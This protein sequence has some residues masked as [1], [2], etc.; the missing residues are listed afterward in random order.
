M[1]VMPALDFEA[2]ARVGGTLIFLMSVANAPRICEG[3]LNAG[4]KPEMP[5]A[6]LMNGTLASQRMIRATLQTLPEEGVRQ[7]V[8]APA[9]LVI[10]EVC[11]LADTCA[12][13]EEK[14]LAG[15]RIVI[16]RPKERSQKLAEHLRDAGAEVLEFPTIELKPVWKKSEK[17]DAG[18]ADKEKLYELVRNLESY[19][20]LVLTSPAG[21]QYFFEL[22]N[23]MQKDFR[24]LSHLRFAVIG[25]GTAFVCREHGIYPD[26]IPE[27]FY[28]ADLGKGLAN[29]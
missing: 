18:T 6:F 26:Y 15:K 23:Q 10:G 14:P 11:A 19:H 21:A 12:W 5:A 2:L 1:E 20:W 22:L 4:M 8:K 16:T 24:S 9:I 13:R 3:L 29:R 7:G 27:R 25:E 28:A 17:A